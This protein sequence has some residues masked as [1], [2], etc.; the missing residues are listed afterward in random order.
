MSR[1][2]A[3]RQTISRF[4]DAGVYLYHRGAAAVTARPNYIQITSPTGDVAVAK[5]VEVS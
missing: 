5:V 2:Y 1:D 4:V 3:L